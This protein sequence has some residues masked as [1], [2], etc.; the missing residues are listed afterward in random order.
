MRMEAPAAALTH[1]FDQ[2]LARES[3]G[4]AK[5]RDSVLELFDHVAA[6]PAVIE[7]ANRIQRGVFRQLQAMRQAPVRGA[8]DAERGLGHVD[9]RELARATALGWIS[10][11]S[12]AADHGDE[13][14][15]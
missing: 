11:P 2:D 15:V 10:G 12:I 14:G 9:D 8:S 4:L 13:R 3:G 5:D 1:V 7:V 6:G